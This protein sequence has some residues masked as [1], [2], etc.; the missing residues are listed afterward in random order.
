MARI[1]L[2]QGNVDCLQVAGR[3]RVFCRSSA[4]ALL[5]FPFLLY[6]APLRDITLVLRKGFR[7]NMP[8]GTVGDEK[9]IR[10]L[11]GLQYRFNGSASRIGNW[12]RRKT[13]IL[14]CIIRIIV[15]LEFA[16]QDG[17]PKRSPSL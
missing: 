10:A 6:V 5:A 11:G 13:I 2:R 3:R 16:A 14:V 7:E 4:P 9:E 15:V 17:P 8:P 1:A 12:S